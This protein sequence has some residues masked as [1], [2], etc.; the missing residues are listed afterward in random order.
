[1]LLSDLAVEIPARLGLRT[2]GLAAI[3]RC[4][5]IKVGSGANFK[6]NFEPARGA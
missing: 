3:F 1:M 5:R 2:R 6:I 4:R